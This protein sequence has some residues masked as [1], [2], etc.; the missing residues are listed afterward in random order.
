MQSC[1]YM[2]KA[3][4]LRTC[5]PNFSHN[6]KNVNI[7]FSSSM[8]FHAIE[9]SFCKRFISLHSIVIRYEGFK[10]EVQPSSN[11]VVMYHYVVTEEDAKH[12]L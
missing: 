10:L 11:I 1:D 5:L 6:D 8:T 3:Y 12:G 7:N 2:L 4:S 9:L